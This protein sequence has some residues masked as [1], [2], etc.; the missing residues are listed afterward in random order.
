MDKE[1]NDLLDEIFAEIQQYEEQ[2]KYTKVGQ[3]IDWS[4]AL[5]MFWLSSDISLC[6]ETTATQ[7]RLRSKI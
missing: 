7:M 5:S 6:F 4:S 3:D 2:L 1:I